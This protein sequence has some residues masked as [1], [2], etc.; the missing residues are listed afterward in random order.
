M[1]WQT[2]LEERQV[3]FTERLLEFLRIP[4]IS[5]LPEHSADPSRRAPG[6]TLWA[7]VTLPR[8]GPPRPLRLG[9]ER[10]PGPIEPLPGS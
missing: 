9:V 5:S 4:S 6:E 1:N 8:Q 2:Y 10:Q 7:E 3:D